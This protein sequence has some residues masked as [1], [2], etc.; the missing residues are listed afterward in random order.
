MWIQRVGIIA[1]VA[2]S[3]VSLSVPVLVL[4]LACVASG[5]EVLFGVGGRPWAWMW[6][7]R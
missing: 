5:V 7:S 6:R 4:V 3:G 1:G 2:A